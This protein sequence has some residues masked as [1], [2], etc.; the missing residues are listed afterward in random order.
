MKRAFPVLVK[1]DEDYPIQAMSS[2]DIEIMFVCTWV[3]RGGL[4]DAHDAARD[5]V[6]V[7]VVLFLCAAEC[8]VRR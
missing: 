3:C 6:T 4:A 2:I 7:I 1:Q 5:L 8:C